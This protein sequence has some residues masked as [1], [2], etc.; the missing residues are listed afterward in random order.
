MEQFYVLCMAQ[1][2]LGFTFCTFSDFSMNFPDF[3]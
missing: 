1:D 2:G 3:S